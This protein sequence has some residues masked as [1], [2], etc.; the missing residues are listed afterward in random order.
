MKFSGKNNNNSNN[1]RRMQ[2]TSN[3]LFQD[4]VVTVDR[5]VN[6]E[7]YHLFCGIVFR[8]SAGMDP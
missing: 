1:C 4:D 8:C 3:M 2:G 5:T 6:K 7:E